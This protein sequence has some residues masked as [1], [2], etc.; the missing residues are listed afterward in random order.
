MDRQRVSS[1]NLHSVGYEP[2]THTL[3]VQFIGGR[4]YDY[5]DVPESVHQF[6]MSAIS[7]GSYF[8]NN[9]KDKYR[10]KRVL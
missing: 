2:T 10:T 7:K 1:S 9:I 4:I 8:D 6:L 3:Q 5:F